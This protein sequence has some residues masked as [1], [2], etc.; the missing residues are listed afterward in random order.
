MGDA[1]HVIFNRSHKECTGNFFI[2]DEV[3]ASAGKTD[4]SEYSVT[5]GAQLMPDFFV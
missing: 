4:L 5:P 3:M 1:A 2:D